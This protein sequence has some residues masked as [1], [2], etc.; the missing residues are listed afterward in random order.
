MKT[1]ENTFEEAINP[2]PQSDSVGLEMTQTEETKRITQNLETVLSAV[3]HDEPITE[4]NLKDLDDSLKNMK[5][6]VGGFEMTIEEVESDPNIQENI[7]IWTEMKNEDFS[8]THKLTRITAEVS[9]YLKSQKDINLNSLT[10]AEGLVL[11]QNIGG[12][13]NLSSLTSADIQEIE[14]SRPDLSGKIVTD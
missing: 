7:K 14:R 1:P 2:K 4:G 3:N 6:N 5:I 8:N 9:K 11:P 13:L 12:Y 10:S